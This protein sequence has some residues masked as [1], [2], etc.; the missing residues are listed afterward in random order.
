MGLVKAKRVA[1]DTTAKPKN[2]AYPTEV[3]LL[4]RIPEKISAKVKRVGKEVTL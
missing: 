3:D 2:I 1:I 4:H